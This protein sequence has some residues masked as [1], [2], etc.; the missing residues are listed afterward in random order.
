MKRIV[1]ELLSESPELG[2][3]ESRRFEME[4]RLGLDVLRSVIGQE[5]VAYVAGP[6]DTGW[7]LYGALVAERL[8]SREALLARWGPE[9]YCARIRE[10]NEAAVRALVN[11]LRQNGH[12]V[13]IDPGPLK[14][15]GW[16]PPH[17]GRFFLEVVQRLVSELWFVD[18]FSTGASKELLLAVT[19][20][21]P[22]MDAV[23]APLAPSRAL[24]CLERAAVRLEQSGLPAAKLRDRVSML[25]RIVSERDG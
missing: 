13:V 24:E 9:T 17:Y 22:C 25:T 23:G 15:P 2:R 10:P 7:R 14:V 21:L 11:R 19:L 3:P 5:G 12:R 20:G 18:G 1:D 8:A 16:G 4:A 6:L